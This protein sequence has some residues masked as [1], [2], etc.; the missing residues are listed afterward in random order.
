MVT[1]AYPE[2]QEEFV[3][4]A[5][6]PWKDTPGDAQKDISRTKSNLQNVWLIPRPHSNGH[7]AARMA[8]FN[9]A[10]RTGNIV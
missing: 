1:G 3:H 9:V 7:F 10:E 5:N 2:G 4:F 8:G 6:D